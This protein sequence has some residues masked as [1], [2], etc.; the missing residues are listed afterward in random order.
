MFLL[1]GEIGGDAS[2][3]ECAP[4]SGEDI[5]E[6]STREEELSDWDCRRSGSLSNGFSSSN[7]SIAAA[8]GVR[9]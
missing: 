5:P 8:R 9:G 6:T 4:T 2:R 1:D 3:A 7:A